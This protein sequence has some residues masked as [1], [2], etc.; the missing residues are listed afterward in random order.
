MDSSKKIKILRII[1]RLNIGGPAIHTILLTA[2]LNN[3]KF[4]SFLACGSIS[5]GEGD[6]SYYAKEKGVA[7]YPIRSL[8]RELNF[9][10]DLFAFGQ[11]YSLI[12]KLKPDI[13]HTHTAKAGSLGRT[14]AL[15]YNLNPWRKKIKIVH[16]FHGHVLSGYFKRLE[17][18]FFIFIERFLARFSDQIITVSQSVKAEL[19]KLGISSDKNILVIP[20][21]LELE[22]F[23]EIPPKAS[24]NSYNVGIVGRLVAIKNHRLFL[25]AAAKICADKYLD[26]CFQVIGDGEDRVD[27]EN[28]AEKLGIGKIEFLGWKNN[29]PSLYSHLDLV[30]LTS[31]NEG[32]PVSLI[33]AM[34]ASKVVVS[35]EVGGVRDLMGNELKLNRSGNGQFK[36]FER[37]ILVR[38]GDSL[39]LASAISFILVDQQ[40]RQSMAASGKEYVRKVFRKERLISDIEDLYKNIALK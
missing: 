17:S 30:V 34:A 10:N 5:P 6:M 19:I 21:G 16:T 28:Y 24:V 26:V 7:I 1:A 15:A 25:D 29:L 36:V 31:L 27:L 18:F 32:T 3:S 35:T 37:G 9:F 40:L 11:I 2:S 39:G 23:L 13:I 12:A 20:L 8:K 4:D 22:K 14:A 33:E 38:S